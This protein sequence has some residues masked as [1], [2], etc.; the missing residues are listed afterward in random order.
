[1]TTNLFSRQ[2]VAKSSRV[3]AAA[4]ALL[5]GLW[6]LTALYIVRTLGPFTWFGVD[7]GYFWAARQVIDEFG[8][9][10]L[11]DPQTVADASAKL[12]LF[13]ASVASVPSMPPPHLPLVHLLLWPFT[14]PDPRL[15]LALWT[16]LNLAIAVALIVYV[17]RGHGR[18][19]T[20]GL[21][22]LSSFPIAYSLAMGQLTLL[23]SGALVCALSQFRRQRPF[24]AGLFLGAILL[25]P[26]YL[27]GLL[28]ALV[29]TRQWRAL[30]GITAV[31]AFLAV[32]S[33]VL[34]GTSGIQALVVSAL[35]FSGVSLVDGVRPEFKSDMVNWSG[36]LEFAT[37]LGVPHVLTRAAAIA[38][39][40]VSIALLPA[41]WRG[42]WHPE[43]P[44][45][46]S[47]I[48]AT[49]LV[50]LLSSSHN[51][52]Y[53]AALLVAPAAVLFCTTQDRALKRLLRVGAVVPTVVFLVLKS[54]SIAA[55]TLTIFMALCLIRTTQGHVAETMT[56]LG[57][58]ATRFEAT[59]RL[60]RISI[61]F[62]AVGGALAG[63][64]RPAR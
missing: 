39:S 29:L 5:I 42:G 57:R 43:S 31:G 1:M 24:I 58:F 64:L 16:I 37:L 36:A 54:P 61:A 3:D 14:T 30:A 50:T 56:D 59:Q 18:G 19:W 47:Q 51:Y 13:G 9:A 34:L 45:F 25:K 63:L 20:L 6:G 17:T 7:F 12:R 55:V 28:V 11:Y 21:F 23:W 27:V 49:F 52:V 8:L 22:M 33:A 60:S 35:H 46:S 53:S 26:Q 40:V 15:G 48:L 62:S 10:A 2:D 38:L 4:G 41:I 44:R 32:S